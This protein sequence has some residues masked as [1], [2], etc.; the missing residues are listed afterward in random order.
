MTYASLTLYAA[1]C[2]A[3]LLLH[4]A[5]AWSLFYITFDSIRLIQ[6]D[7]EYS[8]CIRDPKQLKLYEI[9]LFP[10][11][12]FT[13]DGSDNTFAVPSINSNVSTCSI[14]SIG[15]MITSILIM[16]G[17]LPENKIDIISEDIM[18]FKYW[19]Y[20]G[21]SMYK[22][23]VNNKRYDLGIYASLNSSNE[24]VTTIRMNTTGIADTTR[25]DTR[26][27]ASRP[28]NQW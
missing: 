12:L 18:F 4:L 11:R 6:N 17:V 25:Q 19:I 21:N 7:D 20:L 22:P 26:S 9:N 13:I 1:Y 27:N 16:L 24:F 5:T 8:H 2:I 28:N 3:V 14:V 15:A 23:W 10:R